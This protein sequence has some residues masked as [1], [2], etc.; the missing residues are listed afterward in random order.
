MNGLTRALLLLG[1]AFVVFIGTLTWA[2][3][4]PVQT[5]QERI[6]L[7]FDK[8]PLTQLVMV[9]YDQCE[10]R[11]LV[12]DSEVSKLENLV[13]LKVPSMS[14]A[15]VKSLLAEVLD[16]AGIGIEV[17][18]GYDIVRLLKPKDE[19]DEFHQMIFRPRFRD[20]IDLADQVMVAVRKGTFAHQ[21]RGAQVQV[22]SGNGQPVPETGTNGASLMA[23]QVDKLIFVGPPD[24]VAVV[25]SLL[26]RLDVPSPQV[27][28]SLG[29]YEFQ[30][31]MNQGSAVSAAVSLFKSKIGLAFNGGAGTGSTLKINI[32]SI[33]AAFS[34]LDQDSRFRY[35]ARPRVLAKD[36]EQVSFNAGQD[37]RV[38]GA[39]N[40]DRNGNA[41]QSIV[42]MNAGVMLTATPLVRG[43]V[44]DLTLNQVVSDFVAS[45]N[46]D[47]SVVKRALST[48]IDLQ[49]GFVYV[50]GGLQTTRK[51]QSKK[52]LL[53]FDVGQS[54]DSSEAEIVLLL[55]VRPDILK[56]TV[57]GL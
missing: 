17:R 48:R 33:E 22:S 11:G 29:I 4:A 19:R 5:N 41:V 16:R 37:V 28:I 56:T 47:P 25:E 18:G 35:V 7:T 10:K 39:V 50:V 54:L 32:P 44:V 30:S 51:T 3:A 14:C 1:F 31:G 36:G 34:M 6:A 53:G 45:P 42:T 26:G 20:A 23:K 40:V 15:Q 46:S 52:R 27:E 2:T 57:D 12:F 55:S 21:R 13:S 43:E 24:E 9:F 8:V 38:V 49:P